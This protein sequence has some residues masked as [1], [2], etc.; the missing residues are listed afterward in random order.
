MFNT[1]SLTSWAFLFLA[2]LILN[3][4]SVLGQPA[5]EHTFTQYA[6][7]TEHMIGQCISTLAQT[8]ENSHY[9]LGPCCSMQQSEVVPLSIPSHF[10]N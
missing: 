10:M 3:A 6:I 5:G 2:L 7:S 9:V 8:M 4:Q 1:A